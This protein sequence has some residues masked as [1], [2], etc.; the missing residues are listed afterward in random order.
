MISIIIPSYN[1]AAQI[2]ATLQQLIL[3]RER[4]FEI[5]VA[6]GGSTDHTI[7]IASNYARVIS[8]GK[9]KGLQLNTAAM[10]AAGEILFFVHADMHIPPGAL[11]AISE[12]IHVKGYD[13]GGF[14][15]VFSKYNE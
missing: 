3:L 11:M 15:N 13:G 9:G 1:E 4:P 12:H 10:H 5:I 14:I 8:S 2:E 6:D 7:A